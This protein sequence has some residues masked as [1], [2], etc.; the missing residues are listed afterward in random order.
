MEKKMNLTKEQQ[1][2]YV[3]MKK[4]KELQKNP[5]ENLM[6]I[7]RIQ[8]FLWEKIKLFAKKEMFRMVGEYT[9]ADERMDIEQD[10]V[11]IF[12]EKLPYYNPLRTTPT[13]YFVRYFRE[14][15]S[16]YLRN[17]KVHMTQYDSNNAR[18]ISNAIA[19]YNQRGISYTLDMLSTKTGLTQKV[20][21]ATIQYSANAKLANVEEAYSLHAKELTPEEMIEK[22]ERDEALYNAIRRNTNQEELKLLSLRINA[23]GKKEMS[24]DKIAEC[25]GIPIREV[26]AIINRVICRLNQ[27]HELR[28]QYR[29]QNPYS[30]VVKPISIQDSA[31][32]IME[33]QLLE[34]FIPVM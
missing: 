5:E 2:F 12:L 24:F 9:S 31:C 19:E 10:M 20:I 13:T 4:M 22:K 15:I 14:K 34:S 28:S 3:A 23:S 11:M 6:E 32:E 33:K 27:D 8:L 25:T 7:Q 1:I 29:N 30:C 26:K 17:N 16:C 18:K 21:K